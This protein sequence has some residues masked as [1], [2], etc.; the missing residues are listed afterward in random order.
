MKNYLKYI[1]IV[2]STIIILLVAA[3]IFLLNNKENLDN[4]LLGGENELISGDL[5]NYEENKTEQLI[6]ANSFYTVAKCVSAYLDKI[7][8]NNSLYYG[9]DENG[10]MVKTV[11]DSDI[12]Q[13]IIDILDSNYVK[14]NNINQNNIYSF[15]EKVTEKEMFTPLKINILPGKTTEKYAVYGITQSISNK[16]IRELYIIVTLDVKN[17]TYSIE[18]ILNAS[19]K[20]IGE[21][22]LENQNTPIQKNNENQFEYEQIDNGYISNKYLDSFKKML[23]S[24]PQLAYNYIDETYRNAKFG[25]YKAFEQWINNTNQT[26]KTSALQE[27]NVSIKNDY[28]QYVCIDQNGKNYIFKETAPMEYK[29]ILDTYTIDL[30]EFLEKYEKETEENKVL[31]NIQKVF[32]A[33]NDKDYQYVY[34]KLDNTF[35]ANNFATLQEFEEYIKQNFFEQNKL[36]AGKAEKQGNIYMYQINSTDNTGKNTNTISKTFVMQLKE[37]TDFVMSFQVD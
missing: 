33:I 6:N 3:L 37:G 15:V 31:M 28:K 19:Y 27:Y 18:P 5:Y 7:N 14:T 4:S 24:N 36:T 13:M 30:P 23:L 11:E 34:N 12:A 35:K 16:F 26:I 29:V 1:I 21:I 32:S 22:K 25:N 2:I 10:N 17:Y 9:A 8:T 20:D